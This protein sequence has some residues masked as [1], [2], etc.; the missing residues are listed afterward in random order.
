MH[1]LKKPF[2]I[3]GILVLITAVWWMVQRASRP[4]VYPSPMATLVFKGHVKLAV[5][6]RAAA[7]LLSNSTPHRFCYRIEA[8]AFRAAD[9]WITNPLP[10]S[11]AWT[12]T[13][14]AALSPGGAHEIHAP[15][16]TNGPWRVRL[17]FSEKAPGLAGFKQQVGDFLHNHKPA[18]Q[19][20]KMET[21][22]G[23]TYQ[24]WSPE[25]PP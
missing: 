24:L 14:G 4:P 8:I 11:S 3:F 10:A 13:R 5:T 21:F 16:S 12:A 23:R 2:I 6:N 18:N 15:S 22:A 7:F 1:T 19:W 17:G 20:T 9:G 25:V